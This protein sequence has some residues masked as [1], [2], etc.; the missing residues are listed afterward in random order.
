[1]KEKI[2]RKPLKPIMPCAINLLMRKQ[3]NY[4]LAKKDAERKSA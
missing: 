4:A 2:I 1:M 3:D